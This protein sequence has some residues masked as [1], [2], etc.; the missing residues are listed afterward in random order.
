MKLLFKPEFRNRL[1]EIVYFAPLPMPIII[2]VVDKFIVELETQLK[3]RNISF[4]VSES[5]KKLLAQN[6]NY[7]VPQI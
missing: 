7:L 1:D 3:E 4:D 5:A 6:L 2:K